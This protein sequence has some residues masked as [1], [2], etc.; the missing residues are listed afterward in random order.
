MKAFKANRKLRVLVMLQETLKPPD[1]LEGLRDEEIQPWKT[2][3]D[4]VSTLERL[5]HEVKVVGLY[6]D[7]SALR[8]AIEEFDPHIVFNLLEEFHGYSYYEQHVVSY[9]E[10]KQIPYTGC[11]PRGLTIAHDKALTKKIL[12]YHRIHVPH[13]HVFPLKGKIVKPERLRFPLLV[14]SLIEEG[15]SCISQASIVYDDDKLAER[16]AFV[17]RQTHT[18]AIAEQYIEGREIYASVIGNRR[19][20]M[21]TP[22][23]L[24]MEKLPEGSENIATDRVKWNYKYQEKIG[25]K[26]QPAELAKQQ[27]QVLDRLAKRIYRLL[28]LSGYARLDFRM[29]KD[30][31]IYL[32]EANPNPNLSYGEDFAEAAEKAGVEYPELLQRILNLGMGHDAT[33]PM[34]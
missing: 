31:E 26:T 14:K 9:L 20:Q 10:L 2:E 15:S 34:H 24:V 33:A 5:G 7:L 4:V 27:Q 6:S 8:K 11:N 23:E 19:L 18:P 21:F 1:S 22:W 25:V 16:V 30:G 13:F 32:L 17:H 28:N 12:A 29:T 3:Y